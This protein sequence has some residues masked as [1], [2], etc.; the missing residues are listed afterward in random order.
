MTNRRTKISISWA[1]D[2]VKKHFLSWVCVPAWKV[3]AKD[4]KLHAK[5]LELSVKQFKGK[6]PFLFAGWNASRMAKITEN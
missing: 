4:A 6:I 5:D 2:G 3:A 1:P